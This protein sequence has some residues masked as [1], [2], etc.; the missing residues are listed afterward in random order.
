MTKRG[1]WGIVVG[2]VLA[3]LILAGVWWWHPI[4]RQ[5]PARAIQDP[6]AY[7]QRFFSAE[8]D[9][10]VLTLYYED[11]DHDG[12]PEVFVYT[13]HHLGSAGTCPH[14]VFKHQGG[15]Y[16]LLGQLVMHPIGGYRILPLTEGGDPQL[17]TYERA[18][19]AG[20]NLI[21]IAYRAGH[22]V[23]TRSEWIDRPGDGAPEATNRRWRE[24]IG[25]GQVPWLSDTEEK[26]E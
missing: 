14:L 13:I 10:P 19:G 7:A 15:G 8:F 6:A 20:G 4:G 12:V 11:L 5:M 3:A 25:D 26:Q 21:W 23:K 18:G 17:V 24:V 2:V 22:F 1:T 9:S 16:V